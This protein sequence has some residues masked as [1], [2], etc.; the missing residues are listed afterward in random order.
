MARIAIILGAGPGL[1]A[2][3]S[4][5]L[6]ATHNL[7]LL[8]R[9][10]PGS[11]PSL[12]LPVPPSRIHAATSDGSRPSIDAAISSALSRWPDSRIDLAIF[13]TGGS[14]SLGAFLA[15]KVETL[16]ANMD[17]G[18]V[19]AFNL[20]QAVIPLFLEREPD[21]ISGAR[22]NLIFTGATM[23]IRGGATFSA[24]APGMFARRGLS[25]S[26]ARE[27]GPKGVHVAHVIVDGQ[28]WTPRAREYGVDPNKV[29]ELLS[30]M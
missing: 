22:G 25:Q 20:A 29:Q 9:S 2:S 16:Q 1:A 23:A 27:F 21:A 4:T 5:A 15:Q 28:I 26:L 12:N 6:S 3:L 11:L 8:S 7:I 17:S 19:A 10:L 13:N 18:V 30:R 14:L 24:M